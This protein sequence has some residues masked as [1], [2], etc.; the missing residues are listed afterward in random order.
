M[1]DVAFAGTIEPRTVWIRA[2]ELRIALLCWRQQGH[3]RPPVVR[4]GLQ[5]T[6]STPVSPRYCSPGL[7]KFADNGIFVPVSV[8]GW[9]GGAT[10]PFVLPICRLLL[11]YAALLAHLLY[12]LC[13]PLHHLHLRAVARENVLWENSHRAVPSWR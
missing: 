2:R 4:N 6:G 10:T 12:R 9:E 7:P 13:P 5:D 1:R 11:C 8:C 3:N